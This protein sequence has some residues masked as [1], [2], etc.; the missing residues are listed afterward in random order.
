MLEDIKE[1][2]NGHPRNQESLIPVLQKIEERFGYIPQETIPFIAESL[3]VSSSQVQGVL[4]FYS[5][6]HTAPRGRN[7]VKVCRGTACH[8]RGGRGVLRV[9]QKKLELEDGQTS[10][11][12]SFSLETVA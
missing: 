12:Y 1:I 10:P 5:Q 4:T 2:I 7:L 9:V 6:F 8:V 11:D 3:G